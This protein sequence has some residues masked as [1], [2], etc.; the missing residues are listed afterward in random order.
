MIDILS[1]ASGKI[2]QAH[3]ETLANNAFAASA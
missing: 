2:A 1:E 3:R